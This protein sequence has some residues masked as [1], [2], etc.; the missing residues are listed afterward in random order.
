MFIGRQHEAA[1][2]QSQLEDRSK[3]QLMIVY[4]RRRVG[5]SSLIR[6]CIKKEKRVLSFEGLEGGDTQVQI[7]R[8]LDEL[9]SAT[10]Q[11]KFAAKTWNEAF[12]ALEPSISKGRW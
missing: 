9:A 6:E 2:I 3:A 8:F 1:L 12:R 7:D 5:K 11:V 10:H 4:G